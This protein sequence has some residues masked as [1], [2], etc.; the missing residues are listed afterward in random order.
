MLD[1]ARRWSACS[2]KLCRSWV[3]SGGEGGGNEPERLIGVSAMGVGGGLRAPF[4]PCV[5]VNSWN[6]GFFCAPCGGDCVRSVML[7]VVDGGAASA[8]GVSVPSILS[9]AIG[10]TRGKML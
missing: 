2:L 5:G 8:S 1:R 7:P 9:W 3:V 10:V 4:M 6:V